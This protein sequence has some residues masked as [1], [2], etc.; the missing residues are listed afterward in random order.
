MRRIGIPGRI[1][2]LI[3]ARRFRQLVREGAVAPAFLLSDY[4]LRRR[5]ATLAA[6]VIDLEARLADSAIEMFDKQTGA[7]FAKARA[8]QKRGYEATTRDVGMLMRLFG[9][10]IGSLKLA[11]KEGLDV[12]SALDDDVGWDKLM[13]AAPQV[14]AIAD[15][16]QEDPLVRAADRYMTLRRYAPAFLDAFELRAAGTTNGA[17]AAVKL[18]RQLNATGKRDVPADAPMPFSKKWQ[19]AIREGGTIDR[20]RYETATVALVRDRLRSGDLWVDGTRNYQRFDSYFLPQGDVPAAIVGLPVDTDADT[21]IAE[22][23]RTLDWRLKKFAVALKRGTIEGVELRGGELHVAP[24]VAST[25]AEADRI[26]SAVDQL[27]PQVRITELFAEVAAR[28]GFHERFSELRSGR[29]HPH[30]E[31]LLA[32]V[33]ADATNLGIE[34]M[35]HSSQGVTYAQL[36]WTHGWYLSEENYAAG[37]ACI[38]DAQAALPLARVWGDGT[39][40]SSDGQFFRVGRRG[41]AGEINAK[42]GHESGQKIYTFTSDQYGPFHNRLI[43]ATAGEAPYV[44]DGLVAH[45][46]G[47]EIGTHYTD[48]GGSSDQVFA[49]AR[50]L[51]FRFV[52]RLRDIADRKLGT[53]EPASTYPAIATLIG[54]PINVAIIRECWDEIVRLTASIKAKIV[55]PSVMLRKL[56]GH[57]RQNRLDF[58]LQ[59]IGRIERALFTLDWLE[60][61]TL[62][63]QCQAGLNKGEARHSLAQAVFAHRQ[64]RMSDRTFENQAFKASGLNLATAAIVYWNTLYMSR[65]V[66][67]LKAT[68]MVV[69][70]DLLAHVSPLGWRHISLTGDYLWQEV[71]RRHGGDGFMPLNIPAGRLQAGA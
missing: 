70:D 29:S 39:T 10:T 15:L 22:R 26:D 20:R 12:F 37:L 47:L 3:H 69:P 54:R 9:T 43:S 56:A 55:L 64:G 24:I 44:L 57:Q 8:A 2:E 6:T 27:M 36:A 67:H 11:R 49:L 34:R 50:L 42:Y 14:A 21:Y 5:R 30:P 28:T 23:M 13:R 40:S 52:P 62:R 25:P 19:A 31:A 51:G 53:F 60:S 18:L 48:T 33:L 68:G 16:A 61:K 17:L 1:G 7:L 59:E 41:S 38:I 66:D 46:T 4:S 35:A 71:T 32:A 58:A 45:G 63:Q 65:A